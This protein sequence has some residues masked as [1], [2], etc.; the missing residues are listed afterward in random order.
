MILYHSF[1]IRYVKLNDYSAALMSNRGIIEKTRIIGTIS[2]FDVKNGK[3]L[4]LSL[5]SSFLREGLL[6]RP[7]GNSVYL[8]P[9]YSI[10]SEELKIAYNKI[11]VILSE[12]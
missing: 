2:A 11:A 1:L 6:I 10:S 7:L 5:K 4:N 9:P 8:L 12:L 3:E